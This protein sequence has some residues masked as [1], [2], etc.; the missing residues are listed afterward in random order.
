MGSSRDCAA[1]DVAERFVVPALPAASL[2]YGDI[3][4]R[5]AVPWRVEVPFTVALAT[6]W[7]VLALTVPS[8]T[9]HFAPSMVAASWP[10]AQRLRAGRR[11]RP[12]R[13]ALVN[14]GGMALVGASTAALDSVGAL[15]GPTFAGT[16]GALGETLVMA[17]LGVLVG[18]GFGVKSGA[19]RGS[20][21]A[22]DLRARPGIANLE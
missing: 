16:P 11:L 5:H 6:G 17:G 9:Y 3:D 12:S 14:V 22:D 4:H 13:I 20:G 21:G 7:V 2:R 19:R 10:V 15:S 18:N 8:T 1:P